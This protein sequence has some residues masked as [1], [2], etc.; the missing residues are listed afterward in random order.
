MNINWASR[1]NLL[2]L[3]PRL[4]EERRALYVRAWETH[5]EGRLQAHV[6]IATSG[7]SGETGRLILL[8][9]EALL[10]SARG[11][12][13]HLRSSATD[14]WMKTLP[15]FHVGGLQ[16]RS[17]SHLSGAKIIESKLERWEAA[18]FNEELE[19][20]QATLLSLVPTQLFD[21]VRLGAR[22]PA[23]LRAVVVGG[24]RLEAELHRQALLLGWPALPSYGMTECGSQVATAAVASPEEMLE[25]L[26]D[27]G[28]RIKPLPHVEFRI[29]SAG[30][31]ELK[32]RGLLAAQ[33]RFEGEKAIFEDPKRDGWFTT[34]DQ[35]RLA[36]DGSLIVLGRSQDFVKIGGEGVVMSRLEE[37]IDALKLT[38]AFRF[39]VAVLAAADE[40]L[41]AAVVLLTDAPKGEVQDLVSA[42]DSGVMPFERIRSV[43]HLRA[44]PR[45]PLGKLLRREALA[46]A[47]LKPVGSV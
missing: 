18:R 32:S 47:G 46:M 36:D 22:A 37:R 44:L 28:V 31:I 34:E 35:G 4:T 38:K 21:L 9:K 39:D 45:T 5:V 24:G 2:L 30:F 10:A 23:S 17:R 8:S 41:G 16:I 1:D 13:E 40:R 7:T 42:F 26:Q 27:E 33:I 11:A 14:V 43:H 12:N 25:R 20:S 6:G 29:S 19:A 3:N 15:D